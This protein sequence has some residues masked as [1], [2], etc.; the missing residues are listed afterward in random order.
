MFLVFVVTLSSLSSDSSGQLDIFR[1]DGYT[2]GVDGTEVASS[3]S[4]T[5]YASA[6]SCRALI[7][8]C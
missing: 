4:P 3:N 8:A 6:A 2:F 5:R 1:H 7:A